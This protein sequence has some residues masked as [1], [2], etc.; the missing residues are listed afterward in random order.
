MVYDRHSIL[1]CFTELYL[2]LILIW[3]T[4]CV[5]DINECA[6]FVQDSVSEDDVSSTKQVL[7]QVEATDSKVTLDPLQ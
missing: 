3:V 7:E 2:D 5:V 1:C 4:N 6:F